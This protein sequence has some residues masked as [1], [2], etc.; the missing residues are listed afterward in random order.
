MNALNNVPI[1]LFTAMHFQPILT[2]RTRIRREALQ[3]PFT[4]RSE[5]KNTP[6]V[7]KSYR[8]LNNASLIF[9]DS[10]VLEQE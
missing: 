6:N 3:M 2:P 9:V 10:D 4:S 8:A 7:A 1:I 5:T